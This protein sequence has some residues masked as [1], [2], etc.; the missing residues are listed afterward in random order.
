MNQRSSI[1]LAIAAL[2]SLGS[3]PPLALASSGDPVTALTA[4]VQALGGLWL[5]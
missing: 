1:S 4:H 5:P 3:G 2:V